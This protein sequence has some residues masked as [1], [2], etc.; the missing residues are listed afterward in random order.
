ML[1]A[2]HGYSVSTYLHK[3]LSQGKEIGCFK[4]IVSYEVRSNLKESGTDLREL[5]IRQSVA[6]NLG[7]RGTV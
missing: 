2:T 7:D 4:V 5:I 1:L 3:F 6:D